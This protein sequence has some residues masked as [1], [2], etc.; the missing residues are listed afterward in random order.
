MSEYLL[1]TGR[2]FDKIIPKPEAHLT[3][4]KMKGLIEWQTKFHVAIS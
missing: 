2:H 4:K 3:A 1:Q